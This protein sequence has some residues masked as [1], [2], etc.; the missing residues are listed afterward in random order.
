MAGRHRRVIWS[1]AGVVHIPKFDTKPNPNSNPMR[2]GQMTLRTSELSC[3]SGF[4]ACKLC[5]ECTKFAFRC[6]PMWGELVVFELKHEILKI[7]LSV[8]QLAKRAPLTSAGIQTRR[9]RN[10]MSRHD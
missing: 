2:F 4:E 10:K 5:K 8:S 3:A 1:G 6:H 9:K 7:L